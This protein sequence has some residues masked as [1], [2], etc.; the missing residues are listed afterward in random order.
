MQVSAYLRQGAQSCDLIKAVVTAVGVLLHDEE[1]LQVGHARNL[2]AQ[3]D[4]PRH[5]VNVPAINSD[6]SIMED[7]QNRSRHV[8]LFSELVAHQ[9]SDADQ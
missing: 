8:Y 3:V 5:S 9:L 1:V 6:V 4:V 7:L 2:L